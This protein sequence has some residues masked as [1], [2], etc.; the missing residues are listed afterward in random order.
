MPGK[1]PDVPNDVLKA[2]LEKL[3]NHIWTERELLDQIQRSPQEVGGLALYSVP[4]D[5]LSMPNALNNAQQV[6][7]RVMYHAPSMAVVADVLRSSRDGSLKVNSVS[8][9]A[10][11]ARSYDRLFG[12]IQPGAPQAVPG[13]APPRLLRIPEVY[14][15]AL[16]TKVGGED[17]YLPIV[18]GATRF[19]VGEQF[20]TSQFLAIA[21]QIAEG[22]KRF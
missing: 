7:W 11:L 17:R 9:G 4:L 5:K 10:E 3:P 14:V 19:Q 1:L 12:L 22:V 13:G 8:H 16:W 18:S 2:F 6:G 15:E 21:Q 20:T